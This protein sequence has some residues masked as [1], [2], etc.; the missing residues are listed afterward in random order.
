MGEVRRASILP[1]FFVLAMILAVSCSSSISQ[2]DAEEIA[3]DFVEERVKFFAKDVNDTVDLPVY[4]FDSVTTQ[5][6]G[7]MYIVSIDVSAKLRNETKNGS[8]IVT[9]DNKG[10]IAKIDQP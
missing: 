8:V 9:L 4:T 10:K 7:N 3:K 5:K 6:E 2:Q 1:Y